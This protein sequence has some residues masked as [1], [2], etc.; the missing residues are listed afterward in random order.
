MNT[1]PLFS[2][3]SFLPFFDYYFLG[4]NS[5][6]LFSLSCLEVATFRHEVSDRERG[7]RPHPTQDGGLLTCPHHRDAIYRLPQAT[8]RPVN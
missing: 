7:M 6:I 4:L 8:P 3:V 2:S 1:P 5:Y